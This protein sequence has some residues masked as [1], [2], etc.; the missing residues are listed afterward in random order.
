[1]VLILPWVLELDECEGRPP[2]VLEVD[3]DDLSVLVE[4]VL[5]VFAADVGRQVAHVDARLA[6]AVGHGDKRRV[7]LVRDV[8]CGRR[9]REE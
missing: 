7:L 3:E 4:E 9:R 6:L 8:R 1:M 5:H 2:S